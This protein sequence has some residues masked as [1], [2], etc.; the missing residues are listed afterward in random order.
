MSERP[1][2]FSSFSQAEK[3]V[4]SQSYNTNTKFCFK[5]KSFTDSFSTV[6]MKTSYLKTKKQKSCITQHSG[7]EGGIRAG[8]TCDSECG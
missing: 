2:P 5:K 6:K 4:D 3:R 1:P 8:L 7:M